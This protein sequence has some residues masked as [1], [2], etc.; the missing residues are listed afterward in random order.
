[1]DHQGP[2]FAVCRLLCVNLPRLASAGFFF[3]RPTDVDQAWIVNAGGRRFSFRREQSAMGAI[4]RFQA[5]T[6]WRH[7][8]GETNH[9]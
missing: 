2:R 1:M 8:G 6:A 3:A 5:E 4:D 9:E 7:R